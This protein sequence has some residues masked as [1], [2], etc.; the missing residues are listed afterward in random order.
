MPG[1]GPGFRPGAVLPHENSQQVVS[2]LNSF[3]ARMG[4]DNA[5][6]IPGGTVRM[7]EGGGVRVDA[8]GG[9]SYLVGSNGHLQGIIHGNESASFRGDGK[10]S[11]FRSP[12][13]QIARN[14]R[15]S[16]TIIRNL[17]DHSQVVRLGPRAGYHM[18]TVSRDG[19]QMLQRNYLMG[20]RSFSREYWHH[21]RPILWGGGGYYWDYWYWPGYWY[22]PFYFDWFFDIAS[23]PYPYYWRFHM[24]PGYYGGYFAPWGYYRTGSYWLTDYVIGQ[25]LDTAYLSESNPA[26]GDVASAESAATQ[27]PASA[28]NDPA[29]TPLDD[30]LADQD[31]PISEQLKKKLAREVEWQLKAEKKAQE[32]PDKAPEITGLDA[33]LKTGH[34]FLTD[35]VLNMTTVHGEACSVSAGDVLE[36]VEVPDEGETQAI[37]LVRSSRKGD[38]PAGQGVMVEMENLNEM[39]NNFRAQIN[40]GMKQIYDEQGTNGLP[41]LSAQAGKNAPRLV[42]QAVA[43]TQ[44]EN[45]PSLLDQGERDALKAENAIAELP[46][47]Q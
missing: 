14:P 23:A 5:R 39:H 24:R 19:H 16:Q 3:R 1:S 22:D 47:A 10:L 17:P 28:I 45:L 6:P 44:D 36:L 26:S 30:L 20:G 25:T 35:M 31:T 8:P 34:L 21:R 29:A 46:A 2:Q 32:T 43:A 13:F 11:S 7:R 33:V 4:G 41:R 18:R 40:E 12:N 9:R 27:A 42:D 38:C 37:M 15:G